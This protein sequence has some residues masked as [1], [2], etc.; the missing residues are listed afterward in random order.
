[1]KT[2]VLVITML[3]G[4]LLGGLAA[5]PLAAAGPEL[6]VRSYPLMVVGPDAGTSPG[7]WITAFAAGPD[8]SASGVP[9]FGSGTA[10]TCFGAPSGALV[11]QEPLYFLTHSSGAGIYFVMQTSTLSGTQPVAFNIIQKGVTTPI[12]SG[13]I[14]FTA[15]AV[16]EVDVSGW[17]VPSTK[18]PAT[19]QVIIGPT[20]GG[21]TIK[22]AAKVDIH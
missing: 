22:G 5:P 7:G 21:V 1:M 19:L 13:S 15:N 10:G 18:G 12:I 11:T 14:T 20:G 8:L 6:N 2:N 9:C 4:G 16:N 3:A 17:T